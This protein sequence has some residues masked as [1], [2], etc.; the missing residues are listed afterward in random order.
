MSTPP[1]LLTF[2]Q[3]AQR[4]GI[5]RQRVWALVHKGRLPVVTLGKLN[6]LEAQ[7]VSSY[8]RGKPG[9][10]RKAKA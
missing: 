6:F 9:R 8:Q 7:A 10:P 3:A 2:A 5:S 1:D 4:L